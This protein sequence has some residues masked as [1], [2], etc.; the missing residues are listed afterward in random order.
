MPQVACLLLGNNVLVL[1]RLHVFLQTGLTVPAAR[2]CNIVG[3]CT[4]REAPSPWV[5]LSGRITLLRPI[6]VSTNVSVVFLSTVSR[7]RRPA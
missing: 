5:E 2:L 4:E 7:L 3:G 6:G 1:G